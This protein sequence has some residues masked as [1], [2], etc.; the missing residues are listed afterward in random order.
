MTKCIQ[1]YY[2]F[3]LNN[4]KGY[5]R[6]L[7]NQYLIKNKDEGGTFGDPYQELTAQNN[8]FSTHAYGGSSSKWEE[9]YT[10]C[11]KNS[12]WYLL[13]TENIG[14]FGPFE[15]TYSYDDYTT[16]TGKRR[17][18]EESPEKENPKQIEFSVKLDEQPTLADFAYQNCY[19][20]I[21]APIIKSIA[22]NDGIS[23]YEGDIPPLSEAENRFQN[24]HYIIY[25]ISQPNKIYYLAVYDYSREH[26]Q[27]ISR[28][29]LG[30]D[31]NIEYDT[32]TKIYKGRVYLQ[33]NITKKVKIQKDGVIT[34]QPKI[35]SNQLVSMNLNGSDKRV[36]FKVDHNQFKED[37]ILENYLEY[38]FLNFDITGNEII[39]EVCGGKNIP[40]YRMN[41]NGKN[42][43]LIGCLPKG[44]WYN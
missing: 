26:L 21:K 7:A 5:T 37:K 38:Y 6:N 13:N 27:V 39:V 1:E 22:Y 8:I 24:S 28:Y 23:P 32:I 17:Y 44:E 9:N 36:I 12:E 3:T 2:L 14:R 34:E 33:E 43:M 25:L 29:P 42:N 41:L 31:T 10:F 18:T 40:Y 19:D 30:N 11:Y 15:T 4:G 20:R 35:L 16:G